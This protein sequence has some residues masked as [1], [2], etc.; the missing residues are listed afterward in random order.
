[1]SSFSACVSNRAQGAG[2][3][4]AELCA[5]VERDLA[6]HFENIQRVTD[7]TTLPG[8]LGEMEAHLN[9]KA[10]TDHLLQLLR[11]GTYMSASHT[12]VAQ[13]ATRRTTR[14]ARTWSHI[15]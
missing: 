12:R 7:S 15:Q 8:M 2:E 6:H 10:D 9:R 1:M 11:C 3:A 13:V 4:E 14:P 5:E